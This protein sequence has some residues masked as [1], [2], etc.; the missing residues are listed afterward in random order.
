MTRSTLLYGQLQEGLVHRIMESPAV[1]GATDY[2]SLCLAAK[3]EEKRLAEIKKRRQY[4]TEHKH[5]YTGSSKLEGSNSRPSSIT[6]S[7]LVRCWNCQRAGHISADCKA[8]R[9]GGAER[10]TRGGRPPTTQQILSSEDHQPQLSSEPRD[11]DP[12]PPAGDCSR[13][14]TVSPPRH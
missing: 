10:P 8:P 3:S 11:Q 2:Q 9:R 7:S 5:T 12:P 4:R 1:S 6:P 13:P 14:A